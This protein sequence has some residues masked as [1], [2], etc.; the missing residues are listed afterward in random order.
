M[1]NHSPYHYYGRG[2]DTYLGTESTDLK[3]FRKNEKS[4]SLT[5][6]ERGVLPKLSPSRVDD[7]R[8]SPGPGSYNTANAYS[9]LESQNANQQRKLNFSS[10]GG[11]DREVPFCKYSSINTKIYT[12]GL[13]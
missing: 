3:L 9:K 7:Y 2:P 8:R 13:M 6:T 10:F 12:K 11:A 4:Y 1:A 5:K